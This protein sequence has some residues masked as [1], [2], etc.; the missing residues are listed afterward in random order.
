[1]YIMLNQACS[2]ILPRE[3]RASWPRNKGARARC[4]GE[5]GRHRHRGRTHR[6]S[7][8]SQLP[9]WF[10]PHR[11]RGP[12]PLHAAAAAAL[13]CQAPTRS[14]LA[15]QAGSW[16]PL[17]L[18]APQPPGNAPCH[19]APQ[20]VP[21]PRVRTRA[22]AQPPAAEH[23]AALPHGQACAR[24]MWRGPSHH[25]DGPVRT[26]PRRAHAAPRPLAC[27]ATEGTGALLAGQG[28]IG[29]A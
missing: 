29:A 8:A 7:P 17:V 13:V 14:C 15:L 11:A 6:A 26:K 9:R 27:V 28:A 19:G 3:T 12:G 5:R 16:G 25:L 10:L 22:R 23:A 18:R 4:R 21:A 2:C 1:M 20:Q 24:R